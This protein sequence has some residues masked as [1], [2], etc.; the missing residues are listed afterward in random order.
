M[1]DIATPKDLVVFLEAGQG[2]ETRLG[3]AACLAKR[4]QAHL[5]ATFVVRELALEP[6]AGYAIGAALTSMLADYAKATAASLCSA[7][8]RFDALVRNRSFSAEWRVSYNEGGEALML[9]ARHASLAILGP[10]ARQQGKTT[11]LGLSERFIFES[12][13]P[14][15]LVPKDWPEDRAA[16]RIVVG[17]NGSREAT[18]A[19]AD[20]MPF[21]GSADAVHLIVVPEP[22][23]RGAY[24][25]DP[26][27]DMAAH[28]AR[29]GAQVILEQRA[30]AEA[31][32][33]LL[34]RC[35]DLD[36]DLLVAG[37]R[38]HPHVSDLL[39]GGAT[40]AIFEDVEVPLMMSR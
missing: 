39:L 37:G 5:V 38:A 31:G 14:C 1:V 9:H 27:T 36:A 19:I 13:R 16:R 18:R 28:L 3:Y 8:E 4:W 15:L 12:G 11:R 40:R 34:Q 24:G 35:R 26:G 25:P 7:R 32:A 20:A 33:V 21:L 17:W 22:R 2:R 10:P 29:S 30:G 6:Y 23:L